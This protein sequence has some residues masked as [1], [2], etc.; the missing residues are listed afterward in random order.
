MSRTFANVGIATFLV[1]AAVLFCI[2]ALATPYGVVSYGDDSQPVSYSQEFYMFAVCTSSQTAAG[3]TAQYG[4]VSY[5]QYAQMLADS[6]ASSRTITS[7]CSSLQS[8]LDTVRAMAILSIMTGCFTCFALSLRTSGQ[9]DCVTNRCSSNCQSCGKYAHYLY[10]V[11]LLLWTVMGFISQFGNFNSAFQTGSSSSSSSGGSSSVTTAAPRTYATP[12]PPTYGTTTAG[13]RATSTPSS[14][15]GSNSL[16]VYSCRPTALSDVPNSKQGASVWLFLLALLC[17]VAAVGV[18]LC[19]PHTLND[20]PMPKVPTAIPTY[21]FAPIAPG[22]AAAAA[23]PTS[24][25]SNDDPLASQS[26]K[27]TGIQTVTNVQSSAV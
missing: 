10:L 21:N 19:A 13:P 3:D 26:S 12:S 27:K 5:L 24:Q 16:D 4:C 1:L 7:L 23:S 25:V 22:A 11:L 6:A 20:Q 14:S 18:I 17:E 9:A 8:G 2:G 15:S